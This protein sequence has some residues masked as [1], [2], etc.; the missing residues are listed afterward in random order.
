MV[1][2]EPLT[3]RHLVRDG[4]DFMSNYTPCKRRLEEMF[5]SI[6][7]KPWVSWKCH[8]Q[9]AVGAVHVSSFPFP[10]TE[11]E[12]GMEAAPPF[13]AQGRRVV[14]PG[15]DL[16]SPLTSPCP[17]LLSRL[18]A[19]GVGNH[20][21]GG[22]GGAMSPLRRCQVSVTEPRWPLTT[23]KASLGH[24]PDPA[25][26]RASATGLSQRH[27]H[28]RALSGWPVQAGGNPSV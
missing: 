8:S 24:E 26:L 10:G 6:L 17:C 1:P 28:K 9:R 4:P 19:A 22:A 20:P 16:G 13:R 25:G 21:G 14:A 11:S 5:N 23:R 27:L 3:P 2:A 7:F 18:A 15:R 12:A